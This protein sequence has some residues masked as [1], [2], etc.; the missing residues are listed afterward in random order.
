MTDILRSLNEAEKARV[1][2]IA[3][4]LA[5]HGL[6][7]FVP[8]AHNADG[9]FMPL[10]TGTVAYEKDRVVSFIQQDNI[11]SL[12]TAVGWRWTDNGL[13]VCAACCGRT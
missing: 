6:G 7:I 8:H 13:C 2:E 4:E 5:R 1:E 3:R 10:P 9:Q 12:A 11:P